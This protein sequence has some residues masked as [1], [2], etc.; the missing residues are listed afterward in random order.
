MCQVQLIR[1]AENNVA[2][3]ADAM[4]VV[5]LALCCRLHKTCQ[6]QLCV[7]QYLLLGKATQSQDPLCLA[8]R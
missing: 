5:L 6:L 7:G 1:H 8:F 2:R 4:E 3:L